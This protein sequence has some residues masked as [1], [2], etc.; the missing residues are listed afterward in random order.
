MKTIKINKD[1]NQT[2]KLEDVM[3]MVDKLKSVLEGEKIVA[4]MHPSTDVEV[5]YFCK[6]NN[7]EI[8]Q[9]E[10]FEKSKIYLVPKK[11]LQ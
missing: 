4:C 10:M 5:V 8:L 3:E 11:T 1:I 7:I 9:N 6:E 2:N